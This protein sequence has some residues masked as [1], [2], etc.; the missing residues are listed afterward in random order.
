M[1]KVG[2]RTALY[3]LQAYDPGVEIHQTHYLTAAGI[4]RAEQR[5]L[6][7]G[8]PM[9]VHIDRSRMLARR[10]AM[11]RDITPPWWVITM[12]RDPVARD[13]SYFFQVLPILQ[14]DL[15]PRHQAGR[16]SVDALIDLF[17]QH[18]HDSD[19][20]LHFVHPPTVWFDREI[21]PLFGIDV[22]AAP[23]PH[24]QGFAVYRSESAH[25]L[26]MPLERLDACAGE[27]FRSFF[28][29]DQLPLVHENLS[30]RKHEQQRFAFYELYKPF[31]QRVPLAGDYLDAV[32]DSK[33]VQH[34]Y[35][36]E[37]IAQFR[38]RWA[39]NRT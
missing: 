23:F 37:Q 16:V 24:E 4:Q 39:A 20:P 28:G 1:S 38:S 32:Y 5:M 13:L 18:Q 30:E 2:T 6:R 12:V 34:F 35:T 33:L 11:Q 9:W 10:M 31:T 19:S 17:L 7:M 14:P 22:F 3:S 21:K 25:L 8:E 27:A 29:V 26:V 36:D 15:G